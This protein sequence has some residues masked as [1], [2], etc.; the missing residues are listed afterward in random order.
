M[1]LR[2]AARGSRL[3][4][5]QTREAMEWLQQR[6][7]GFEWVH[8]VVKTS[9]DRFQDRPIHEL[10]V[11][12]AFTREVDRAVLEG[13]ADVAVHSMKDLPSRLHPELEIIAVPP[14]MDPR[15][16]LVPRPG[17]HGEPRPGMVVGTGS[18]RRR[19]LL[20]H[21]YPGV[22]VK[23]LRGNLD[24]RLRRLE[25]GVY[26]FIV[27]AEA[28]LSRIGYT[29]PRT[30]LPLDKWPPAPGQGLLA[31][32]ARRGSRAWS[33][34]RGIVDERAAAEMRAERAFLQA[35]RLGCKA[36]VGAVAVARGGSVWMKAVALDEAGRVVA[37]VEDEAPLGGEEELGSRIGL[38]VRRALSDGPG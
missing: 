38:V 23:G 36:P 10:G 21:Y 25:E 3:S 19:S 27:A 31:V 7:G 37:S 29:G 32:V 18:A 5:I 8:V 13:R 9:G 15:D 16:S 33:L 35:A 17:L 1:I 26:D 2:V 22:E 30:V 20:L 14:R 4:R 24:T 12:G 6:A 34:L 28:G 11:E